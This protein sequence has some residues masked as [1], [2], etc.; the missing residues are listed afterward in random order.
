MEAQAQLPVYEIERI[1]EEPTALATSPNADPEIEIAPK[2][3][4]ASAGIAATRLLRAADLLVAHPP[5]VKNYNDGT[6]GIQFNV[7]G[8]RSEE[9][10]E[11]LRDELDAHVKNWVK[12]LAHKAAEEL[13]AVALG[14]A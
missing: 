5:R 11:D 14:A 3:S 4:F 7:P 1:A 8:I 13:A 12:T 2:R 6:W 10:A 9:V